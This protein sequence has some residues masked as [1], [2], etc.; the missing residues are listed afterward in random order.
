[1]QDAEVELIMLTMVKS[2]QTYDQVVEV[3]YC[4]QICPSTFPSLSPSR[5]DVDLLL[6]STG[7]GVS[8]NCRTR[9]QTLESESKDSEIRT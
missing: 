4:G 6:T 8:Q 2:V 1:M 7:I 3:R 9:Y 5:A